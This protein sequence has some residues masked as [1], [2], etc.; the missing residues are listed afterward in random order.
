MT[1][2][3]ALIEWRAVCIVEEMLRVEVKKNFEAGNKLGAQ[4]AGKGKPLEVFEWQLLNGKRSPCLNGNRCP[5]ETVGVRH[6]LVCS[7]PRMPG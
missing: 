7:R 2:I 6:S 1:D 5:H 4:G 3:S